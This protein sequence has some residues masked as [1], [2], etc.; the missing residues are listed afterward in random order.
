MYMLQKEELDMAR[1]MCGEI[2]GP[3][4]RR[5]QYGI[6]GTEALSYKT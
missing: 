5:W 4:K 6:Y 2:A 1:I 3:L